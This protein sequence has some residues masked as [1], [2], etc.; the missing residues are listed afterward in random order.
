[1]SGRKNNFY[2]YAFY[3]KRS[4]DGFRKNSAYNTQTLYISGGYQI[5]KKADLAFDFTQYD[6][7][8]QQPGGLTDADM[9]VDITKS[10]RTRNWFSTPWF[11]GNIKFNWEISNNQRLQIMAFALTCIR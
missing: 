1:V 2:Y 3:D 8:S 4:A 7:L 6:M 10:L 9:S 5:S 11:T